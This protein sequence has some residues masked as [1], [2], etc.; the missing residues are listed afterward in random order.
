MAIIAI[1]L[2]KLLDPISFI[3]VLIISFFSREK[4]IIPVAAVIGAVVTETML[5][6][7][8]ITRTWGHGV[9]PGLMASGIHAILCYWFIRK[10]KKKEPAK[11]DT[12]EQ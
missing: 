7:T 4:W 9:I 11:S 8:Q 3:V 6:S 10:F 5:T 12:R 1:L 2:A